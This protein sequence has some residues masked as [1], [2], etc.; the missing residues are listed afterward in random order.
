MLFLDIY[1]RSVYILSILSE[2]IVITTNSRSDHNAGVL[3]SILE[4]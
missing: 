1:I 3:S 4:V 2:K